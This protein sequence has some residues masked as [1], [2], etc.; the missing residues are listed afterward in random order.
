MSLKRMTIDF[1]STFSIFI[2]LLTFCTVGS[3][4]SDIFTMGNIVAATPFDYK[5]TGAGLFNASI[6]TIDPAKQRPIEELFFIARSFRYVSD[7]SDK[8]QSAVVTEERGA[9]DCEDKAVWLFTQLIHN[10]YHNVRLVIGKYR[11]FDTRLHVWVICSDKKGNTC[12]L[13]PSIRQRVSYLLGFDPGFYKPFYSYDG[14]NRY[15]YF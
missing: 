4:E 5:M 13:D 12:L 14:K 1:K 15:K 11:G 7:G 2:Y 6:I 9:G 10:G 8:W 3:A